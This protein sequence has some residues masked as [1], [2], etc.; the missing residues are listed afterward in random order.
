MASITSVTTD[1]NL[2]EEEEEEQEPVPRRTKPVGAAVSKSSYAVSASR[3]SGTLSGN[4]RS[5]RESRYRV[6]SQTPVQ[7]NREARRNSTVT[8][9][10]QGQEKAKEV[11][12]I[13]WSTNKDRLI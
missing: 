2:V 12:E 13:T 8:T 11:Q 10:S 9:V 4:E 1:P 6:L 7:G 3:L 5:G